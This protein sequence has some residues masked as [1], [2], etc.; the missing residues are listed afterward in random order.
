MSGRLKKAASLI[1]LGLAFGMPA[2]AQQTP[3]AQPSGTVN[4]VLS[5]PRVDPQMQYL[6]E[7]QKK[8]GWQVTPSGLQYRVVRRAAGSPPRPLLSDDVTVNYRG[9]LIDGTE[10]DSSYARGRP[11]TFPLSKVVRGWQ[12]ALSMMRVGEQWELAIPGNLGYGLRGQPDGGIP[13]NATLLF[14]VELLAIRKP[15]M[16]NLLARPGTVR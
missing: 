4:D 13:P 6:V 9:L 1:V 7:N 11:A 15:D 8:P 10:F 14:T 16:T 3:Q 2:A 5:M 12:E